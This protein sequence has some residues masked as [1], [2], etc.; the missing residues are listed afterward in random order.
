MNRKKELHEKEKVLR[1]NIATY[2]LSFP[3]FGT[4]LY[5][6]FDLHMLGFMHYMIYFFLH[7]AALPFFFQTFV[8]SMH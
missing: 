7:D 3:S 1:V 6:S 8:I 5:G 4:C 2:F